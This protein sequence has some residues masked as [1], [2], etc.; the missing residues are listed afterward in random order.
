MYKSAAIKEGDFE[1]NGQHFGYSGKTGYS[2]GAHLHFVVRGKRD[3]SIPI[4]FTGY[5][6]EVLKKWQ[7]YKVVE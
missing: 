4:Y 5:P 1:I 7:V 3:H 2:G 6:D